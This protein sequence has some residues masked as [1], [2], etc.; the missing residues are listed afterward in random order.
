MSTVGNRFA[1]N[2]G[3]DIGDVD[4]TSIAPGTGA[5]NLGKAE[6]TVHTGGDVGV[7]VL[8]VR[9]SSQVNF[10]AD[11]DYVPF[12][13]NDSG[14]IRVSVGRSEI[15]TTG[16]IL[17]V[18]D[19][20]NGLDLDPNTWRTSTS[21]GTVT[22]TGTELLLTSGTANSHYARICTW[23]RATW[24]TGTSNKFG[25]E[26]RIASSDDDVTFKVGVGWATTGMPVITNGAYFKIIGSTISVNT[27]RNTIETSVASGSFNG[28]Y[29]APVLTNNN[30][31]E[32]LYTFEKVEFFINNVVIHTATFKTTSWSGG[33]VNFHAFADVTNTGVS[34]AIAY[35]IKMMNIVR[36]GSGII[37]M[38]RYYHIS[39]P[40]TTH[41][42]KYSGGFLHKIIFNNNIDTTLT[43]TDILDV[44]T[45]ATIGV[46]ST[47]AASGE[48]SYNVPFF[49]SLIMTVAVGGDGL[50]ATVIYE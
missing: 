49:H 7:M 41:I 24:N 16:Q 48:W 25:S 47:V 8:G 28:T 6:D 39:G 9:Q 1:L 40:A 18:G 15:L 4:V 5:T 13:V 42:V 17:V 10:G 38:P 20:F 14:E 2:S 21:S 30:L 43:I 50:D 12:S 46:I 45:D 36:M 37:N 23:A 27:M 11:G 19:V 29:L 35:T 44:D 33:T 31:F 26:F 32:I 22:Q 34:T 3:V